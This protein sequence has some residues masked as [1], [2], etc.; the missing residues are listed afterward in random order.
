LLVA[1]LFVLL[2]QFERWLHQH[3]FK[4]GWL[5]T[6]SSQT[7]T[8]LY[9]TFFL[10][11]VLLYEVVY[12]L[13]AGLLNVRAD[14]AITWPEK[15]EIGEL[16]LNFVKLSKK[17]GPVK[18]AIISAA[19]PIVGLVA[20]WLIANNVFN[21]PEVVSLMGSGKLTDVAAAM[22]K[23]LSTQDVWLWVYLAFTISN[24]MMPSNWRDLRGWWV[25]IG[26]AAF[27]MV[28]LF[29]LGIGSQLVADSLTGP[30]TTAL[31]LLAGTFAIIIFLDLFMTGVLAII[32][33]TIEWLTGDSATF[34]NGKMVVMRRSELK[35]L[36]E[37]ELQRAR[38][39]T[40]RRPAAVAG[41]PPSIYKL[42]L[43]LPGAPGKEAITQLPSAIVTPEERPAGVPAIGIG[44]RRG[45]DVITGTATEKTPAARPLTTPKP[46]AP[47]KPTLP[48]AKATADE[49]EEKPALLS[50]G[51]HEISEEAEQPVPPRT[52]EPMPLRGTPAIKLDGEEQPARRPSLSPAIEDKATAPSEA[53]E[54]PP[55]TPQLRPFAP[56]RPSVP[57]KADADDP[58]AKRP[59]QSPS[60]SDRTP[61]TSGT[62]KPPTIPQRASPFTPLRGTPA[63]KP[64]MAEDKAKERPSLT[65]TPG[66]KKPDM[67]GRTNPPVP[68]RASPFAPLRGTP[69]SKPEAD[70]S[71]EERPAVPRGLSPDRPPQRAN[72]LTPLRGAPAPKPKE[73]DDEEERPARPR[74]LDADRPSQ[75]PSPFSPSRS[76]L[77]RPQLDDDEDDLTY[78]E[79][80]LT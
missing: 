50:S 47:L 63:V 28:I 2:R 45:P 55:A 38:Q 65:P 66:E 70:E 12:W 54:K 69:S 31:N 43:P 37:Q 16:R 5:L 68:Q 30:L 20:I 17:A 61:E 64:G 14:R 29:M 11:G 53:S 32:E 51:S 44:D 39:K 10:P 52:S 23:L 74:R 13:A 7:T 48:I 75:R 60:S 72:P 3:I 15:Q 26:I 25:I 33:N 42:Q 41:G 79:D 58:V 24:T 40:S 67:P 27:G 49:L 36:R 80:D 21:I 76:P 19:P 56:A 59:S 71:S 1:G 9:Y 6:K 77:T 34:T 62:N 18:V 35:A 8:I 78:E 22:Q 4:V 46:F 73:D 57:A